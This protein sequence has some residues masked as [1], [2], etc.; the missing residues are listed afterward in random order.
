[1][2]SVLHKFLW[3]RAFATVAHTFREPEM[4]DFFFRVSSNRPAMR[5]V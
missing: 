5:M 2:I 4:A 1:M 3:E